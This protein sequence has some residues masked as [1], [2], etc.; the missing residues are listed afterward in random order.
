MS[1]TSRLSM[2]SSY[3]MSH[4]PVIEEDEVCAPRTPLSS[5]PSFSPFPS[6]GRHRHSYPRFP[7]PAYSAAAP[8]SRNTYVPPTSPLSRDK[9]P[10]IPPQR[11]KWYR[12]VLLSLIGIAFIV[13]LVV[14]LVVGLRRQQKVSITTDNNEPAPLLFPDG[15]YAFITALYDTSMACTSDPNTFRCF[16]STVYNASQQQDNTTAD[17]A[18]TTF[19]W[20]IREAQD[21]GQYLISSSAPS[22]VL[23]QFSNITPALLDGNQDSERLAFELPMAIAVQHVNVT[24][25][26]AEP[27]I[28][29]TCYFNTTT[30][31]ATVWTRRPAEYHPRN[32]TTDGGVDPWPYAV[33]VEQLVGPGPD[34]PDCR[35]ADGNRVGN[36]T[37]GGSCACRY[38]NFGLG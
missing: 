26:T 28:A 5:S 38:R 25:I 37:A 7:P 21:Q 11:Q 9:G 4:M 31:R 17:A 27:T 18:M 33:E 20:S 30:I 15:S 24:A 34:V 19:F 35:D 1:P 22:E 36:L 29:A 32:S 14:G 10:R 16:P 12:V 3:S 6:M 23:P 2:P 8:A 13:G